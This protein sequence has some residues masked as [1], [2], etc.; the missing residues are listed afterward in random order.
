MAELE[1][2]P[3]DDPVEPVEVELKV[4]TDQVYVGNMDS[5]ESE[6]VTMSNIGLLDELRYSMRSNQSLILG[7]TQSGI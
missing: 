2:K 4:I 7:L 5:D 1:I 6:L 3:L